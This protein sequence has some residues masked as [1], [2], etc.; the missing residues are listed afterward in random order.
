MLIDLLIKKDV[1]SAKE[2][3]KA[4]KKLTTDESEFLNRFHQYTLEGIIVYIFG[5]IFNSQNESPAV[6]LST[7]VDQ[8]DRVARSARTSGMKCKEYLRSKCDIDR[9]SLT[10]NR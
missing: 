3:L 8:L 4:S 7:L 1:P 5:N 9:H 10:A 6:R 2:Y